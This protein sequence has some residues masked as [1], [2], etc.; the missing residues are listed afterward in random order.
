MLAGFVG[1]TGENGKGDGES[2]DDGE[3]ENG[4][5]VSEI[6]LRTG[7]HSCNVGRGIGTPFVV[8]RDG[9]GEG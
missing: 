1:T 3:C 9:P 5:L 8:G 7:R 2:T 6:L 4:V